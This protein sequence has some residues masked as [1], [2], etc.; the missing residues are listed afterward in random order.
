M[1]VLKQFDAY[2]LRA[3]LVPALLAA[4]PAVAALALLISWKSLDLSN[5]VATVAT[6][7]LLLAIADAT[8]ERGRAVEAAIYPGRRGMPSVVLFRRNDATLNAGTKDRFRAALARKLGVT[9]PTAEEEAGNQDTADAFYE[10]CGDWLRKNTRDT[11][12]FPLL[13]T[14]NV[15]YGFRRNLLGVKWIALTLNV[16]VVVICVAL[17]WRQSWSIDTPDGKR[18]CVV[19]IVAAAHALYMLLAV[20]RSA[21]L[22]AAHAY[23][24]ELIL[25]SEAFTATSRAR[26]TP[27]AKSDT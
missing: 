15:T 25:S 11:K 26:K 14:E 1:D 24:R 17:L 23:G 12:R 6:L 18:I 27:T 7:V 10:Q 20:R 16:L 9:A 5:S 21:V 3:R 19:L 4:A 13:F 2:T 8:R 22:D